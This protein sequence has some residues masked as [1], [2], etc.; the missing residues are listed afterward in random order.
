MQSGPSNLLLVFIKQG[1]MVLNKV[2][3]FASK[4]LN[5]PSPKSYVKSGRQICSI[6]VQFISQNPIG[7]NQKC[8]KRT[9]EVLIKYGP[10]GDNQKYL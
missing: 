6:D 4:C 9:F 1:A 8:L 5:R 3:H 10:T 2:Q 7:D